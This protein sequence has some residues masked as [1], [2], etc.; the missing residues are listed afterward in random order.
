VVANLQST[1]AEL[2]SYDDKIITFEAV[3]ASDSGRLVT[4]RQPLQPKNTQTFSP[5]PQKLAYGMDGPQDIKPSMYGAPV[6]NGPRVGPCPTILGP[7]S[8]FTPFKE[9]LMDKMKISYPGSSAAQIQDSIRKY[10][11]AL[12]PAHRAST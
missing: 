7:L 3:K 5:P 4:T 6:P 11:E 12:S 2:D 8:D 1:M 9:S 10:W